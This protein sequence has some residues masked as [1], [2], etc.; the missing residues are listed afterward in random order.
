MNLKLR[1]VITSIAILCIINPIYSKESTIFG[2]IEIGSKGIKMTVLDVANI[3]KGNYAV[4]SFWT[5]N[6]GI[7][8]GIAKDG[9]LAKEDIDKAVATVIANY[10]KMLYDFEIADENIFIVGSSGVVMAKN[11]QIL[12]NK[13]YLA[14]TKT[15][16]FIDA[17]TE[18]KMLLKGCVP[19]E[20]NINSVI[21]DIGGG[22]IE[23]GYVDVRN[24]DVFVF[25][26]LSVNYGT[27][28]LTETIIKNSKQDNLSEFKARLFRFLPISRK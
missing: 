26:P 10:S 1:F 3:K 16:A 21:L 4:K 9:N 12:A 22:N 23:G 5:E 6:I 25:F 7:A 20:E 28:T 19:P 11:T 27:I 15:L 13:I 17:Q 24:N 8:K 14:T 18:G 2:G